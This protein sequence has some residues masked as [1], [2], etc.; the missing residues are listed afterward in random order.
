[1]YREYVPYLLDTL[2][3]RGMVHG[4]QFYFV[5]AF[6]FVKNKKQKTKTKKKNNNKKK[7][8]KKKTVALHLTCQLDN[9]HKML[10]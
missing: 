10:F 1:M 4:L 8:K 9:L 3:W 2:H 5:F 7:K 6:F